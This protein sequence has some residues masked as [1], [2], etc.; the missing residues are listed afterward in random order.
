M[1]ALR[2]P[3]SPGFTSEAA[4]DLAD[5]LMVLAEPTRLRILALLH[6]SGPMTGVEIV[7]CFR[8]KQ[9]TISHHLRLLAEAGLITSRKEG[10]FTVRSLRA[11]RMSALA[12]LLDPGGAA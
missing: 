3:F 1:T 10:V 6:A 2:T 4:V 11:G 12:H 9:P 8:L 5:T 7:A